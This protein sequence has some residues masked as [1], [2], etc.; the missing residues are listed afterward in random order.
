MTAICPLMPVRRN[1][2][3]AWESCEGLAQKDG[4]STTPPGF[5]VYWGLGWRGC[6]LGALDWLHHAL[7]W[8]VEG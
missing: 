3:Q 5:R 6:G 4:Q 1:G 7:C 2:N 8:P